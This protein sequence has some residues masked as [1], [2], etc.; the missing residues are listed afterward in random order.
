MATA[1]LSWYSINSTGDVLTFSGDRFQV[2]GDVDVVGGNYLREG[3]PIFG[4]L[5]GEGA[6][7]DSVSLPIGCFI[8]YPWPE[9]VTELPFG[10]LK[11]DG[12]F[13][14]RVNFA[15]L[16][17]ILGTKYGIPP[18][19]F[20]QTHFNLP[21]FTNYIIKYVGTGGAQ[22]TDYLP[23]GS[24]FLISWNIDPYPSGY[25]KCDG[26]D[27]LIED[28]P[29]LFASIGYSFSPYSSGN[30][31]RLPDIFNHGIKFK[32]TTDSENGSIT[33]WISIPGSD[34]IYYP[35]RVAVGLTTPARLLHI[36]TTARL[37]SVDFYRE[38]VVTGRKSRIFMIESDARNTPDGPIG[39]AGVNPS[40]MA[41]SYNGGLGLFDGLAQ[42]QF[43]IVSYSGSLTATPTPV[44]VVEK[45]ID[46]NLASAI[47]GKVGIGTNSIQAKLHVR[48][49]GVGPAGLFESNATQNN[50]TV[51]QV[52]G[53]AGTG[54]VVN[55]ESRVGIGTKEPICPLE[56]TSQQT[57]TVGPYAYLYYPPSGPVT[58]IQ[59]T[60]DS[61]SI[62]IRTNGSIWVDGA[63]FI[64]SSDSRI[65]KDIEKICD[66]DALSKLRLIEPHTYNYIDEGKGKEKVYGF[67]AQQV[68]EHF[69]YAVTMSKNFIPDVY[70]IIKPDFRTFTLPVGERSGRLKLFTALGE[71]II[72]LTD[73][74]FAKGDLLGEDLFPDGTV[75]AYGFEVEDFHTLDKMYLFTVNFAA[76]QELDREVEDL[77]RKNEELV[78]E[79]KLI[80]SKLFGID[81]QLRD[82][83]ALLVEKGVI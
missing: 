66:K 74:K 12:T 67:I 69:P 23:I 68:R 36:S 81:A 62:A 19:P 6:G 47:N 37:G 41:L 75:F 63:R 17:E 21:N 27:V 76:T 3:I 13:I 10:F 5:D 71:K 83:K 40:G 35:S 11:C 51:F 55:G 58:D 60:P 1:S 39:I 34:H 49:G 42:N 56:V 82:L 43:G 77:K 80:K 20:D 70:S 18:P 59:A 14:S 7:G 31:F 22:S 73:R 29:L 15:A 25:V 46:Q 28:Y 9:D 24:V 64:A 54:F 30:Q 61:Q 38:G 8:P 79:N 4:G 32:V 50:Q 45:F 44:L 16:F 53:L 65:K 33:P 52:R 2:V 26:A 72:T 57:L 48:N 78:K